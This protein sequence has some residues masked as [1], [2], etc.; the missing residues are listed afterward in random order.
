L[1]DVSFAATHH[2][3]VAP[4]V[5]FTDF[6]TF[7]QFPVPVMGTQVSFAH[8]AE[9]FVPLQLPLQKLKTYPP[10]PSPACQ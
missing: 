2:A 5:I 6:V 1:F 8:P 4:L 7:D 9:Q 3:I 10:S